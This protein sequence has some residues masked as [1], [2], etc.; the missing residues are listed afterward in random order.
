MEAIYSVTHYIKL[1]FVF[2]HTPTAPAFKR[3]DNKKESDRSAV[4]RRGAFSLTVGGSYIM[5]YI[6]TSPLWQPVNAA[7]LQSERFTAQTVEM[8]ASSRR[9]KTGSVCR[10]RRAPHPEE[11]KVFFITEKP[12]PRVT[13]PLRTPLREQRGKNKSVWEEK[14]MRGY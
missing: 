9:G 3:R 11:V 7:D 1:Q 2:C 8:W 6:S 14:T 4:R 10:R 12:Q 5:T 13:Q